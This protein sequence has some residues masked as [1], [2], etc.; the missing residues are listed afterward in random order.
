MENTR[1]N[2]QN[3][4]AS[5]T[6]TEDESNY[7]SE[8]TLGRIATASPDGRPHV[9]PVAYEFDGRYIYF[10]G[11]NNAKSLKYRD[12]LKNP[13]VAFVVDDVRTVNPWRP[14]G[15]EIRGMAEVLKDGQCVRI[16]ASSKRAWGLSRRPRLS[17]L[18]S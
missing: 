2:Q 12:I 5:V 9:V 15:I 1:Q 16:T 10:S 13:K 14:R 4:E 6:F 8:Q 11:W 17:D 18:S 7:L 3:S